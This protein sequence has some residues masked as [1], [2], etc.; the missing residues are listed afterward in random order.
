MD[1]GNSWTVLARVFLLATL[2]AWSLI[3][4]GRLTRRNHR[5]TWSRRAIQ[6]LAGVGIGV[7]AFWL[8][9]WAVPKGTGSASSRDLILA[10]GHRFSPDT[11]SNGLR[12]LFYF[13]LT[14]GAC[15]W[16]LATDRRRRERVRVFPVLE[17][18]FW[19]AVFMFLWPIE[20]TPT[21]LVIAPVMIAAVAV[22]AASPWAGPPIPIAYPIKS[23]GRSRHSYA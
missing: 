2:L 3:L 15:R 10:T 9:G 20:S 6:L 14:A 5:N 1:A 12:Y 16:W 8:D 19:G 7:L 22:Q 11:I 4:V 13:G 17:A 18:G 21:M 23:R